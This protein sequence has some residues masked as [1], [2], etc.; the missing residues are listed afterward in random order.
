MIFSKTIAARHISAFIAVAI[1]AACGGESA[2]KRSGPAA[3]PSFSDEAVT[4]QAAPGEVDPLTGV[5]VVRRGDP[6][7]NPTTRVVGAALTVAETCVGIPSETAPAVVL[8]SWDDY[9]EVAD[10]YDVMST[11]AVIAYGEPRDTVVV[12]AA[13]ARGWHVLDRLVHEF[14]HHLLRQADATGN[15]DHGS[16]FFGRCRVTQTPSWWEER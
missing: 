1:L 7:R 8:L 5:K 3:K 4:W 15:D 16:P 6:E 10:R 13:G 11:G 14:V 2:S 9:D 12:L